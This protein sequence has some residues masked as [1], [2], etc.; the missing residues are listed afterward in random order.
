[1][2]VDQFHFLAW[3]NHWIL[4]NLIEYIGTGC[5]TH[6]PS[7]IFLLCRLYQHSLVILV[8]L[9]NCN[10]YELHECA[11]AVRSLPQRAYLDWLYYSQTWTE[12]LSGSA[13][14][15]AL[16]FM[17]DDMIAVA[18][19]LVLCSS[20]WLLTSHFRSKDIWAGCI[21]HRPGPMS[22]LFQFTGCSRH[23]SCYYRD[24]TY[25]MSITLAWWNSWALEF[26][27]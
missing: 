13:C 22:W 16:P 25:V 5:I 14:R 10:K 3:V 26:T 1:M 24:W 2:I 4:I 27:C 9:W 6:I 12:I 11:V 23:S 8:I 17:L 19:L 21:T 18:F 15:S 20:V 7:P